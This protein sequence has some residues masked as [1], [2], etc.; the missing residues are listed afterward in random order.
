MDNASII[1]REPELRLIGERLEAAA[2]GRASTV[3]LV[4]EP[5]IG[6][7]TLLRE[8]HRRGELL[9]FAV[10][11]GR[12]TELESEIPFGLA[13]EA[14]DRVLGRIDPAWLAS[15]GEDR[16]GE[17]AS[18]LPSVSEL[19]RHLT[20]GPPPT[21]SRWHQAVRPVLEAIAR[22]RPL[23]LCLDDVHWADDA[24]LELLTHLLHRPAAGGVLLVITYRPR[25]APTMLL[26]AVSAA[27][28]AGSASVA[29][30]RPLTEEAAG[31]LVGDGLDR[32]DL[33]VL[34]TESGGN[35]FY[36]SELAHLR[37]TT[38]GQA[39]C[40]WPRPADDHVP[41]AIS[42]EIAREVDQASPRGR[43]LLTAAAVAGEPFTLELAT[44][45]AGLGVEEAPEA[46]DELL[47]LGLVDPADAPRRFVFRHPI[48]RRA[49]YVSA[50]AGSRLA[51]HACAADALAAS[52]APLAE[53]AHHVERSASPADQHAAELL[54]R[55]AHEVAPRAPGT[56]ARWF[57]RALSLLPDD[58]PAERR[59]TLLLPLAAALDSAGQTTDSRARLTEALALLTSDQVAL[60]AAVAASIARLD[61]A[62]GEHGETQELLHEA[63]L[64]SGD[65][66][67]AEATALKLKLA[68]EHWL[69]ANPAEMVRFAT[70]ARTEA[71]ALDDQA[72][73]GSA[74][75][76]VAVAL[77]QVGE[78]EAA[79]L[80]AD[81]AARLFDGLADTEVATRAEALVALCAAEL[82]LERFVASAGHSERAISICATTGQR[83][84]LVLATCVLGAT[85]LS[86][87]RLAEADA[88]VAD[89]IESAEAAEDPLRLWA[90]SLRSRVLT[91]RGDLEAAI[92]AG[93]EA[94]SLAERLPTTLLGWLADYSLAVALIETGQPERGRDR[95]LDRAGGPDLEEVDPSWRTLVYETLTGAELA[96]GELEAAQ[97][98]TERAAS[99]AAELGLPGRLAQAGRAE[100]SLR[101][102]RGDA[103]HAV[104]LALDAARRFT[105]V[106]RRLDAALAAMVGGRAL[107]VLGARRE[108]IER[109]A[110]AHSELAACGAVR[111]RDEA[112]RELRRLGR[113]VVRPGE[114][115]DSTE[116]FDSLSGRERDVVALVARGMTNREIASQLFLSPKTVERHL[117]RIF[118]KLGVS[119]RVA[120]AS[121]IERARLGNGRG[122]GLDSPGT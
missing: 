78:T 58:A 3:A 32:A 19:G 51:A 1:D 40:P 56:A 119:S 61:H 118:V 7:T 9:G 38:N 10:L 71:G 87:G 96:R 44:R 46:L 33:Q 109:L 42:A 67:S 84:W 111:R 41:E 39:R 104:E 106:G 97:R 52:G 69:G 92:H 34:Y 77:A 105:G 66:L 6:K 37:S 5:G 45:I 75:S 16:V 82:R 112:A 8:A 100:A 72:L 102:A 93:E 110:H 91:I 107:A 68:V 115:G 108:A 59:Y 14:L 43:R 2:G 18:V 48:V 26:E 36:F 88:V 64:A 11:D 35:P 65:A 49:V 83:S 122:E 21:R 79:K 20:A 86:E 17:L 27:E 55:A 57:A 116:G 101:L 80:Q 62:A 30:L 50:P 25:P 98:W 63:L 99:V 28:R 4:G 76:L 114:P 113:P 73:R 95:I 89:A 94:A 22:E 15:L 47:A 60:K 74:S 54:R 81:D 31:E 117:S 24:S 53:R 70:E 90:F 12:S 29:E 120:L 85:R 121:A 23:L 103:R 13:V